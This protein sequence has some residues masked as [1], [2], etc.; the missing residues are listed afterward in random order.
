MRKISLFLLS[1]VAFVTFSCTTVTRIESEPSGAKVYLDGAYIGTTPLT[2]KLS[3]F[4]G[5]EYVLT[6]IKDGYQIYRAGVER[7]VKTGPV[8]GGVVTS[9]LTLGILGWVPFVYC[10]GPKENQLIILYEKPEKSDG[11]EAE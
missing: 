6:V 10:Y 7:E 8:V 11:A 2:Q 9:I 4:A 5:K 3:N 1:C